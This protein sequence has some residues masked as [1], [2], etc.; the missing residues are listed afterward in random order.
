MTIQEFQ[1][2]INAGIKLAMLAKDKIR[3]ETLRS[4]N[5]AIV[6]AEKSAN[7]KAVNH[8]DILNSL[9][10]QRQQSIDAFDKGGNLELAGI[11]QV[12]L[13]ILESFM[14]SKLADNEI[15]DIVLKMLKNEFKGVTMKE[16]GTVINAF[17]LKYPG[18]NIGV[19][20]NTIKANI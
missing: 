18:Q 12:E 6:N 14:P 1:V 5:N 7:A 4:I 8:I 19:V 10:K 3:L 2:E 15:A 13:T 16:Q 9:A 17:K 20:I 11:E